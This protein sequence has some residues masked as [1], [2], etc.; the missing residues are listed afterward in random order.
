M[1]DIGLYLRENLIVTTETTIIDFAGE[2]VQN[3]SLEEK[4][5]LMCIEPELWGMLGWMPRKNWCKWKSIYM[6]E[7]HIS[8]FM[9]GSVLGA[10]WLVI[11]DKEKSFSMDKF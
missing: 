11:M 1:F 3:M 9:F 2:A 6:K 7:M 10:R 4:M 5:K 8:K